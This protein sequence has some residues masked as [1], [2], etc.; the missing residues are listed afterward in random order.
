[1]EVEFSCEER[2]ICPECGAQLYQEVWED[3]RKVYLLCEENGCDY[4]NIVEYRD[5]KFRV[6]YRDEFKA[7]VVAENLEEA[8]RKLD[9]VTWKRTCHYLWRDYLSARY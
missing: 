8:I 9:D 1:M 2:T 7:E 3:E 6:T 5:I 4:E